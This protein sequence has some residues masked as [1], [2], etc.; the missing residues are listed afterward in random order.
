VVGSSRVHMG[1]K[2]NFR[3]VVCLFQVDFLNIIFHCFQMN[4]S[5][6]PCDGDRVDTF[7]KPFSLQDAGYIN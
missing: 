6:R 5:L 2:S 3:G 1:S 7:K 4:K